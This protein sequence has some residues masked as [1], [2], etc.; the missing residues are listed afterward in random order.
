MIPENSLLGFL[1]QTASWRPSNDCHAA[2]VLLPFGLLPS[3]AILSCGTCCK[4][5]LMQA[6]L[7]CFDMMHVTN[8]PCATSHTL[9]ACIVYCTCHCNRYIVEGLEE[10]ISRHQGLLVG[11]AGTQRIRQLPPVPSGLFTSRIWISWRICTPNWLNPCRTA[12]SNIFR[13][14]IYACPA[15]SGTPP[16]GLPYPVLSSLAPL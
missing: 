8:V 11:H 7:C 16:P 6:T 1:L 15:P 14:N 10:P 5:T 12:C 3:T 4:Q 9:P 2:V 13:T